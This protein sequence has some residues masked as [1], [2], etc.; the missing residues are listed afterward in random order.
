[1][2]ADADRIERA[3]QLLA[4][5]EAKLPERV[6]RGQRGR[7]RAVGALA[8]AHGGPEDAISAF[9]AWHEAGVERCAYCSLHRLGQAYELA[10]Q[11]DSALAVYERAATADDLLGMYGWPS[12]V[13]PTYKR[14]GEL[15]EKRGNRER[16]IH[17]YNEFVEL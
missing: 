1:L 15:Y 5:Y 17:Y 13:A 3:E 6:R 8:L 9:Q 12:A 16:A 10:G 14:I 11:L 4:E 2:Y 7:F